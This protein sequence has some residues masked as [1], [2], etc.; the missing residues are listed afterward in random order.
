MQMP[1]TPQRD[2]EVITV[3]LDAEDRELMQKL[4]DAERLTRSDVIRRAIRAYAKQLG[5]LPKSKRGK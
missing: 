2:F 1:Q 3:K 4:V 5:V